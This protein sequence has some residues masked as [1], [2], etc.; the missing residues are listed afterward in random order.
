MG[1]MWGAQLAEDKKEDKKGQCEDF[2]LLRLN[3]PEAP[4]H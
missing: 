3:A 1:R 2:C 4:R